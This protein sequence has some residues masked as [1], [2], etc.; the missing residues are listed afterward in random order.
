[1]HSTT[2]PKLNGHFDRENDSQ[3]NNHHVADLCHMPRKEHMN[4]LRKVMCTVILMYNVR[5][6][7]CKAARS[8]LF[9]PNVLRNTPA[10][11]FASDWHPYGKAYN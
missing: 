4:T 1:M 2:L 7:I 3:T 9:C 5:Q 8:K 11:C 6:N 10:S